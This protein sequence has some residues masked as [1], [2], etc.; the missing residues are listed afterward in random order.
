MAIL[1]GKI[2]PH[3]PE[4]QDVR[5][6]AEATARAFSPSS[7]LCRGAKRRQQGKRSPERRGE[8]VWQPL[9]VVLATIFLLL[10][11][12]PL[13]P[14]SNLGYGRSPVA[15][16]HDDPHIREITIACG[17]QGVIGHVTVYNDSS[18]AMI[19]SF[20]IRLAYRDERSG[21][22]IPVSES[23]R[24]VTSGLAAG[25]TATLPYGPLPLT[26]LPTSATVIRSESDVEGASSASIPK[27]QE[28]AASSARPVATSPQAT[29][30][31]SAPRPGRY[32]VR[33]GETLSEIAARFNT[34]V[35]T[36]VAAN[37]LTDSSF[38]MAGQELLVPPPTAGL[39]ATP[40]ATRTSTATSTP[41]SPPEAPA[42]V[43]SHSASASQGVSPPLLLSGVTSL[44]GDQ[45]VWLVAALSALILIIVL[46]VVRRFS[47]RQASQGPQKTGSLPESLADR[48]QA[49]EEEP[50]PPGQEATFESGSESAARE[51]SDDTA[52]EDGGLSAELAAIFTE[53]A[54]REGSIQTLLEGL[55]P[56]AASDLL[57]EAQ[58]LVALVKQRSGLS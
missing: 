55:E 34:T 1:P 44:V 58:R 14:G 5:R 48:W 22:W 56:V 16:A 17:P 53:S 29:A 52:E 19:V 45:L 18:L 13:M 35:E 2:R 20:N 3:S 26:G 46:L 38:I 37:G 54:L 57:Q 41:G 47:A 15:R 10:V 36:I 51:A 12:G 49:A 31:A 33:P 43:D 32:T 4:Q 42:L 8:R 25:Q 6:Q 7:L 11:G 27:C 23:A 40:P 21:K 24:R 9:A 50:A 39:T 30:T 28:E